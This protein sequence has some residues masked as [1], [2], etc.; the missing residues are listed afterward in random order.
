MILFIRKIPAETRYNDIAEFVEP[1]LK[2]SLLRRAGF[3]SK[4]E[5]IGYRDIQLNSLEFHALVTIEPERVGFRA[6]KALKGKR[7][8][9]KLVLVRQYFERDWHN[10][11]RQ[12]F[13]PPPPGI[14]E[15]RV[16]DR[17]RGKNL[18]R[19]TDISNY[20]SN[21]GDFARKNL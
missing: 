20:F 6:I 14:A 19:I 3:I 8:R 17:R 15:R 18:E 10:D 2:G 9:N 4:I 7:L 11:P 12:G 1:A 16:A 5:I 21:A 13:D